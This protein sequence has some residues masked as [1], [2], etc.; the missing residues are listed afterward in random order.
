MVMSF[1]VPK[2]LW[3]KHKSTILETAKYDELVFEKI[4]KDQE[5]KGTAIKP[6]NFNM[7]QI[8]AFR[9]RMEDALRAITRTTVRE[10]REKELRM[11][12]LSSEKLKQYFDENPEDLQQLRHDKELHPARIQPHLKHVPDYLLPKKD[13]MNVIQNIGYVSFHKQD[14]RRARHVRVSKFKGKSKS[15]KNRNDPLKSFKL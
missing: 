8:N 5:A 4:K 10:A 7:E 14:T 6:Y 15:F 13:R 1:I 9:Y 12:I 2:E 3:G 11:E